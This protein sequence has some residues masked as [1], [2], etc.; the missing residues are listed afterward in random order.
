M[1]CTDLDAF[2]WHIT[3]AD[4]VVVVFLEPF[5]RKLRTALQESGL[6]DQDKNISEKLDDL[7]KLRTPVVVKGKEV[8]VGDS[9]AVQVLREYK[10]MDKQNSAS[11]ILIRVFAGDIKPPEDPGAAAAPPVPAP[12]A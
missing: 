8:K 6:G 9:F 3:G 12:Q 1:Q 7:I 11:R 4:D 5:I 10:A 2:V